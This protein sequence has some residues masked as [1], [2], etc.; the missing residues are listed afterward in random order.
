MR[1]MDNVTDLQ[2]G[3]QADNQIGVFGKIVAGI[4]LVSFTVASIIFIIAYWP[5][6]LPDPKGNVAPLYRHQLFHITLAGIP[7]STNT[8]AG[9]LIHIN[10][11]LLILVA[12]GGFA[13]N[14]IH[15]ATSFVT[16]IGDKKF[17]RSWILWYCVKPFTAAALALGF[18]FVL[19]GGF[20]NTSAE[21]PNINL[22]GVMTIAILTG[23][24]TDT[25][26]LKMK[27]VFEVL[28]KPKDEREGK[29]DEVPLKPKEEQAT[30]K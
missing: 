12:L 11:L 22:Y 29:R 8:A 5:D 27:E 3:K 4:L 18:Y 15:I 1:C 17:E 7:E 9:P 21:A 23:L 24:F 10:T 14:M 2:T 26:T 28:F 30:G 20:L 25:A 6:K 13:G 19:R 16:F